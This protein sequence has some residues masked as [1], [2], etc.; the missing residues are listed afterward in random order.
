MT[1][2][3]PFKDNRNRLVA[4]TLMAFKGNDMDHFIDKFSQLARLTRHQG[5]LSL[6]K[7]KQSESSK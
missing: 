7:P 3:K 4:D 1:T 2:L 6:I 5:Q